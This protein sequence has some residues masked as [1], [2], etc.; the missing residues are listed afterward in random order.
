V[1]YKATIVLVIKH[2]TLFQHKIKYLLFR[3]IQSPNNDVQEC[4]IELSRITIR[5]MSVKR[6]LVG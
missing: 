6:L 1:K 3:E 2:P 5:A 4:E